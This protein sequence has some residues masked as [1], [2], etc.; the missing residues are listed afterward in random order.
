MTIELK[1][2]FNNGNTSKGT[3]SGQK[4]IS[5]A[6]ALAGIGLQVGDSITITSIS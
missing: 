3:F 2:T 5:S 6:L 4:D 1:Y